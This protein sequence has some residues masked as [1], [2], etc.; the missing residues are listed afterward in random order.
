MA[1]AVLG[2][3]QLA[4]DFQA[5]RTT[6]YGIPIPRTALPVTIL[7]FIASGG[8]AVQVEIL[9]YTVKANWFC[10]IDEIL[11]GF[12]GAPL[13]PGDATFTVDID[14][15]LGVTNSGYSEKDYG[16]FPFAVGSFTLGRLWWCN[17]RHRNKE[18]I[19]V[20]VTDN[21]GVGAG[22]FQ[23]ALLG[24]EWPETSHGS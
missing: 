23:A 18:T 19:R 5:A 11:L 2:S 16:A 1:A 22:V 21:I 3:Q 9:E 17:F 6:K 7:G 15:P 13:N 14:R 20:K 8:M 4:H 10:L 24:W 12:T